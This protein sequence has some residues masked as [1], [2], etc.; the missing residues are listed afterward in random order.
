[1]APRLLIVTHDA[2]LASAYQAR[3]MREQ[4]AVECRLTAREGLARA[5]QWSPQIILLDVTLPGTNGL[6]VLKSMRDVPWLSQTHVVLLVE[7]TL[8]R[9]VIDDCCLWGAGSVFYKDTGSVSEL[10]E[11]L[12]TILS[13]FDT[14]ESTKH[15]I[16]NPK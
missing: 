15:Q 13:S 8:Q 7:H 5:R 14:F 9:S 11:R 1:M 6:D 4:F 16:P 10:A 12:Q 3:C 2:I